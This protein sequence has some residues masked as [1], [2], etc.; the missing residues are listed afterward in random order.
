M[1]PNDVIASN[2]STVADLNVAII[3][4]DGETTAGVYEIDLASGADIELTQ[5][6]EAINLA[7]GV[8]LDIE[9]DG[10]TLDG[11]NE[12]TGVSDNQRGL[13]VYAG[14]VMVENV[15]IANASAIGGTGAGVGGGG[16]GLGGGL[17]VA[18]DGNVTLNDVVF[19]DDTATGGNGSA[20]TAGGG[21]GLGGAGASGAPGGGGGAGG[22]GGVGG[23]AGSAGIIYGAP[24][25]GHGGGGTGSP[26]G[27]GGI[28][29]D[30]GGPSGGGG[31]AGGMF[32][33]G[34]PAGGG[35]GGVDG[36]SG[37]FGGGGGGFG[38]GG[39]GGPFNGGG[40]GFGGGGG[41]GLDIGGDGGFGGGGGGGSPQ[42][43]AGGFGAGAGSHGAGGGGLGAGGDIF[44]QQGGSLTIA[45][46]STMSGG[47]VQGGAGGASGAGGGMALGSGI[48]IQGDQSVTF[49]PSA[50]ATQTIDDVIAD[51]TGSEGASA[52]TGAGSLILDGAGTLDLAAANSFAGGVTIEDG[53]LELGAASAAGFGAIDF[54]GVATLIIDVATTPTNAIDGFQA[55]D[56]IDLVATA[57]QSSF[58]TIW[59]PADGV[60]EIVDTA[61]SNAVE[62]ELDVTG[63]AQ[64]TLLSLAALG[65]AGLSVT[66]SSMPLLQTGAG[67]VIVGSIQ[68]QAYSAY[69]DLS[70]DGVPAGVEYLFTN[71]T[72][73]PYSAYADVYAAGGELIGI[74]ELE[75]GLTGQSYTSV[76][77]DF[78]GSGPVV[79]AAFTGVSGA[80]YSSYQDDYV[81]GVF[82]GSQFTYTTAPAGAT[83]SS[84]ETD[85]DQAGNFAG[86]QFFFTNIQGQSYTGEEEDF[87]AGGALSS[88][89]LTGIAGQ[90][91][92][93]LELDYSDGTYE[94]YKAYYTDVTGQSFTSEEVD[95]SA[96]NELEKV[97][98][99]GMTSTPYSSVEQDYSGGALADV[100]YDFT[101][102]TGASSYSYQ[103]EDNASGGALWET[104]DLNS[105]GHDLI[106]LASGQ[107]LTSLGD[108]TMTGD[109][110]TTFVLDAVYG[111]DTITNLAG[112]DIVSMPD[113]EFTSFTALSKA[114]SFANGS[115]VITA[116]DGDTLTLNGITKPT[117]LHRLSGV[118][119]FHA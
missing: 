57:F 68:G 7:T 85:Y 116:G 34:F 22:G 87:D 25:G 96:A 81:G 73:Q 5:A 108:D 119:T 83:Y 51:M 92:S 35:G 3:A 6:L 4:A 88:V 49:A 60:M 114:A 30:S 98:Y 56:A 43:G 109:G 36:G 86:D 50:G 44:I 17:F 27:G 95:V 14:T 118:F 78:A 11:K 23:D 55:G 65:A 80:A 53:A 41:G 117:Q 24:G 115:A 39:G 26:L 75:T 104:L 107:T 31:G 18:A 76:E 1:S 82:A 45:G 13:F 12:T 106:A 112:G 61:N 69:E 62:A 59:W 100:I 20:G 111:A 79:R 77:Y 33:D 103:V 8:T 47:A 84:D 91:Y 32:G 42:S 66:A 110:A 74:N 113:S 99:S 16:A 89:L 19:S 93:S 15:T 52:Q 102:V 97:V 10:A 37:G 90:A 40:G 29:G 48:F 28:P 71:V 105:G 9:G 54:A 21:G 70:A 46:G 67:D 58:E 72:G 38:G 63:T 94:G 101:N 2:V 64:G